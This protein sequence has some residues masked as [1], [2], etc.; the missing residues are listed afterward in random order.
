MIAAHVA[1]GFGT[2]R[3]YTAEHANEA[4]EKY[5]DTD[6]EGRKLSVF[7]DKFA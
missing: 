1:Q 5:H 7:I 6:L 3:F 4:I 2:V